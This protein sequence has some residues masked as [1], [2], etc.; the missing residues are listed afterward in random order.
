MVL[1][2]WRLSAMPGFRGNLELKAE[3]MIEETDS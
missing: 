2:R 1:F 3:V